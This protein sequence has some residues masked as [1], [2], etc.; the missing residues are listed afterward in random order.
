MT[1]KKHTKYA[2]LGLL[3]T[4]HQTGY[5]IKQ[6]MDQ[7]LTHFWKISYGQIYPIL[8]QLTDEGLVTVD[9]A[10]NEGR[11]KKLYYVT[12]KGQSALQRWLSEPIDNL[13][14]NKSEFLLK[15]FFSKHESIRSTITKIQQ[16]EQA[17]QGRYQTYKGIEASIGD[18]S[19]S[20]DELFWQ[21]TLEYG[22]Y[23]TKAGITWC[24]DMLEKLHKSIQK[25]D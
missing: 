18:A 12:A 7:S 14:T 21:M 1:T 13:P 16:H 5:A 4:G 10:T 11:N 24:Q 25:E 15:L 20:D 9:E 6:L 2:I 17:L 19:V 22:I 23:Q 3:T 8:K